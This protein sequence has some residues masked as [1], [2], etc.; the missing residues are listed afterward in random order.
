MENIMK[1]LMIFMLISALGSTV[2]LAENTNYD[3]SSKYELEQS[4]NNFSEVK[5]KETAE[6]KDI[7]Q[8]QKTNPAEQTT[9]QVKYEFKT[10]AENTEKATVK[11]PEKIIKT[12]T[13]KTEQG[14][15]KKLNT[16]QSY[17]GTKKTKKVNEKS[18]KNKNKKK[19]NEKNQTPDMLF[20][21]RIIDLNIVPE[22]TRTIERL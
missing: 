18:F 19:K 11:N 22:E 4:N 5:S 13:N 6:T 7:N 12:E 10:T 1:K 16:Q 14:F 8:I 21:F 15:E 9:Q 17:N 2:V 20:N 3:T